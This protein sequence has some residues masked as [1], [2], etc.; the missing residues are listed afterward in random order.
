[1]IDDFRQEIK[2]ISWDFEEREVEV[3]GLTNREMIDVDGI[4]IRLIEGQPMKVPYWVAEIL[5]EEGLA[6]I[7]DDADVNF[8]KLA[9]LAHLEAQSKKL[10]ALNSPLFLRR[11][12]AEIKR[13]DSENNKMAMRKLSSIEGS[14]N[15]IMRHRMRKILTYARTGE[16]ESKLKMMFSSEEEWLYKKLNLLLTEWPQLLSLPPF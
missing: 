9:E 15:K 4:K 2:R 5:V 8:R 10:V 7:T 3:L 13:L 1:M 16:Q 6:A 14:L 12:A 11:V